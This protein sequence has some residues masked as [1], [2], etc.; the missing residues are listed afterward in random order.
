MKKSRK[1]LIFA[2]TLTLSPFIVYVMGA[3]ILIKSD[4]FNFRVDG[5]MLL[6]D[7]NANLGKNNLH[8]GVACKYWSGLKF[9]VINKV[10][11]N[12]KSNNCRFIEF[13]L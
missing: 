9:V 6:Q 13:G 3:G 10:Y 5:D 2:S 1:F 12:S 4:S 8:L 7:K 11:K